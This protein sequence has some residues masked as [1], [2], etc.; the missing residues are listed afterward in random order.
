MLTVVTHPLDKRR[1][2]YLLAVVVAACTC[3]A[4]QSNPRRFDAWPIYYH[5][6]IAGRKET[7]II[8]PIV[9]SVKRPDRTAEGVYPLV[10][11]FTEPTH[12]TNSLEVL[13]PIFID[14]SG[15][16]RHKIWLLPIF[17]YTD[18]KQQ[19]KYT[20]TTVFPILWWGTGRDGDSY[21]AFFPF[22]GTIR[23]R[24]A[25]QEIYFVVFPIYSRTMLEA[26]TNNNVLF[27]LI[28]WGKGGNR[29][30]SR[31]IPFYTYYHKQGEPKLWS[32]LWPFFSFSASDG[33]E[34]K[35]RSMFYF[36][37]FYGYDH[38]PE[39]RT[40]AV[41][42][43]L[44]TFE[45]K[46]GSDYYSW[47]GPWPLCRMQEDKDFSR[48]QFWPFY[49]RLVNKGSTKKYYLWPVYRT[50]HNDAE[51]IAQDDWSVLLALVHKT[52]TDKLQKTTETRTG[53][54]PLFRYYRKPD[55][56][57]W[58]YT[59]A[60]LWIHDEPGFERV[61]SR[62]WRIFEY[63]DDKKRDEKSVR[64]V[65]RLV[66]YDRYAKYRTFNF[67]GPLFRYE[68]EPGVQ[69]QYS[70]LSGLLTVGNRGGSAVFK[71]LYIP[72]ASGKE[73][74]PAN[75]KVIDLGEAP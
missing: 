60:P 22:Y 14:R 33:T 8:W 10:T 20:K 37:P 47:I 18:H 59:L 56:T 74:P 61:Y 29:E 17:F 42:W 58:F 67:I 45:K 52:F 6:E 3:G 43:P 13:Y 65:W 16:T 62:F 1:I 39:K 21:F 41:L 25:R 46:R 54:W 9:E 11:H 30:N 40:W 51:R 44:F 75:E 26:H 28:A 23:D 24:L 31:F 53:F 32:V 73:P 55:G 12:N 48:T 63:L 50:Y 72:F 38:T 4:C 64:F 27:P 70:L 19:T 68:Y 69:R 2:A 57:R 35:P 36:F 34:T 5:E 66:R 7:D 49:G 15:D 71:F